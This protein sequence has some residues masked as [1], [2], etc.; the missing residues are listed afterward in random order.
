MVFSLITLWVR[1]RELQNSSMTKLFPLV[2]E[3]LGGHSFLFLK[4]VVWVTIIYI[5]I[6]ICKI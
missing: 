4:K 6:Y 3:I 1:E 2:S 5:Y